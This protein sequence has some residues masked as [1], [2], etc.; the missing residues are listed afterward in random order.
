MVLTWED[1]TNKLEWISESGTL[2]VILSSIEK[3]HYNLKEG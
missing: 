3:G 2:V 1:R